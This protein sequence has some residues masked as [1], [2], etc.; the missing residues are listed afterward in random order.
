VSK[1][2]SILKNGSNGYQYFTNLYGQTNNIHEAEALIQDIA[3]GGFTHYSELKSFELKS[4]TSTKITNIS[5]RLL[6]Y[7]YKTCLSPHEA[8]DNS[9]LS[10]QL[11]NFSDYLSKSQELWNLWENLWEN[12][13]PM[14]SR[15][16]NI[17]STLRQKCYRRPDNIQ[18]S[19][20]LSVEDV[21][22]L[23]VHLSPEY[24]PSSW[25]LIFSSAQHGNNWTL[26]QSN[27]LERGATL[28]IIRE[29]GAEGRVFGGF[30]SCEWC[31]KPKFY[32]NSDSFL[33]QLQPYLQLFKSSGINQNYQYFNHGAQTFPN[34]LGFGG[35]IDYFGLWLDSSF[36]R[37]NSKAAP[38]STTFGNTQLSTNE[39]FEIDHGK[40][41]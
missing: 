12:V 15:D 10:L 32:G 37:G 41:S 7:L 20:L 8:D 29:K 40:I 2:G 38:H 1:I 19:Q 39:T 4:D 17:T 21:W 9:S 3:L 23:D 16:I 11:E 33:F 22:F 24:R 18:S 26:F 30:A 35:Q 5:D 31:I 28:L 36:I 13:F 27:V 25:K 34:G 6:H 14:I